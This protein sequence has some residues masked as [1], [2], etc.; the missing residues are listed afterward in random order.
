MELFEPLAVKPRAVKDVD[1]SGVVTREEFIDGLLE[2][3]LQDV[4]LSSL[5]QLKLGL[6]SGR[7]A[8]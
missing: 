5:Q 4:S 7:D 6:Y 1:K 3:M 2:I 8:V